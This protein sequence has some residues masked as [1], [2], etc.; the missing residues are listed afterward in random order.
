MWA[1]MANEG[2]FVIFFSI[3]MVSTIEFAVW[4]KNAYFRDSHEPY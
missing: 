3:R 1:Q 4:K 2:V